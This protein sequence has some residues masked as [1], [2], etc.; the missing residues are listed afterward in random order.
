[1]S[2]GRRIV[3]TL[4]LFAVAAVAA[5]AFV[6]CAQRAARRLP[7]IVLLVADDVGWDDL[8]TYGHPHV[9]T[10]NLDRLAREGMRFDQAFLTCSTCSPS[11]CS[12]LTGRYPHAT[13]APDAHD[14]LPPEQSTF[15][16]RLRAAGYYAASAGKW[17]LGD[18]AIRRFDKVNRSFSPSGCDY[19]LDLLRDRPKKKPFFLWLASNDAHRPYERTT[20]PP[21][22]DSAAVVPSFLPAISEIQ[23]ELALYYV[24]ITRLDDYVGRVLAELERQGV[25]RD[26]F[27]LFISDNGRPFPRCKTTLYDSGIKTAWIVRF[28]G[29]VAPGSRS[30]RLVS[31][32][33]IASTMLDLAGLPPE[34]AMMGRSILPLLNSGTATIRD[35]VFAEQNWHDYA[36]RRR[37]VR[38]SR[39]K[40]I[41]DF[42]PEFPLTPPADIVRTITFQAMRKLRDLGKLT[43]D[44]MASFVAPRPVEE[45]FDVQSDPDELRN[46]AGDAAHA[47]VLADMRARLAR[48]QSETNDGN[49]ASLRPDEFDRETGVRIRGN[50][51]PH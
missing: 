22:P 37:A 51:H 24:E 4:A 50:P 36:A 27:V 34:P 26:T 17:H 29:R 15:V 16:E 33:D 38:T 7:N 13:G 25:A 48:W 11:R 21:Y 44:Q 30:N 19:W 8:G 20:Y 1:M 3:G 39:F 9:R 49:P 32:V 14:P 40:Y 10:P 18:D 42:S 46:L 23:V 2:L 28:P 5:G 43:P 41:R 6:S 12:I 35:E 45:L 47:A 31:S